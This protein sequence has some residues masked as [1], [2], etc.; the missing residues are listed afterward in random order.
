M[1]I[2]Y[3]FLREGSSDPLEVVW[4]DGELSPPESPVEGLELPNEGALILGDRGSLLHNF[5]TGEIRLVPGEQFPESDLPEQEMDRP[6]SH[7]AEWAEACKGRGST[8]SDFQ[9]GARLTETILAGIVAYR[10][11]KRLDWNGP[12]MRAENCPEADSLIR[13]TVRPGWVDNS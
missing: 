3:E 9:Y 2:R 8:M 4:Y 12:E 6:S 13:P 11:G 10:L 5:R 1:K 7:Y